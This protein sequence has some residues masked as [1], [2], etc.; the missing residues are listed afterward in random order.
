MSGTGSCI[1]NYLAEHP[2]LET[3][4]FHQSRQE[5]ENVL[6]AK[7]KS[8]KLNKNEPE[9]L[10][11]KLPALSLQQRLLNFE[12]QNQEFLEKQRT[13]LENFLEK[14]KQQQELF[15]Q[16][17]A[18]LLQE[19]QELL[20]KSFELTFLCSKKEEEPL[21]GPS[22]VNFTTGNEKYIFS[23]SQTLATSSTL[24]K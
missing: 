24:S 19:Q 13:N 18:V 14:Q 10:D 12:K 11:V 6:S 20:K 22:S 3:E 15:L 5:S 17:Q 1:R 7:S 21:Q 9:E 8:S 4:K 23:N 2:D 16:Q